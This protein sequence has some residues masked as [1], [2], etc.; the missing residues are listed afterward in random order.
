MR[1]ICDECKKEFNFKLRNKKVGAYEITY[2]KCP[3]CG[4]EYTVAYDNDKTKNLRL[5]IKTVVETLN[6]NPDKSVR[7]KK[8]RERGY[9]VEML[10]QEEAKIKTNIKGE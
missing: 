2:F 5:R 1:V 4:R 8:E 6:H 9:L 7:M 10:K 3:K